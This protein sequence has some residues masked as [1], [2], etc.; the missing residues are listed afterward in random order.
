MTKSD[1]TPLAVL[2]ALLAVVL[3]SC[4][5]A[6]S[7]WRVFGNT[8]DEPEHLAAGIELL[9]QGK[10]TYDI[11]HPP[12]ARVLLA[13]G[14]W[15]S[16]AHSENTPPPNGEP[17]GQKILY[18]EGHYD[19]YLSLARA[20]T[21]PFLA[22]L[23]VVTFLWARSVTTP[24]VSL[25]AALLLTTTPAVIG[26]GALATIDI[27][28]ASTTLFA[29]WF[30]RRWLA[31]G[32]LLDA[33]ALGL[34]SGLALGTKLS[35]LPFAGVGGPLLWLLA[36]WERRRRGLPPVASPSRWALGG[37]LIVLLIGVVLTEAYGGRFIYLTNAQHKFSQAL[38]YLF[39]FHGFLHDVA[40]QVFSWVKVPEAVKWFLGGIEAVSVHNQNGHLSYL[41]GESRAQGWYYFYL[42]ALAV[43]T[44][45]PFLVLGILGLVRLAW[46]G[47][48]SSDARIL[49]PP[50][51]F[52]AL[53]LFVSLFSHINIGVRH[54]LVLYPLLAI[55]AATLLASL[56]DRLRGL[57]SERLRLVLGGVLVTLTLWPAVVVVREWPDYLAYFNLLAPDP[58]QVLVDS[59]L[60][61]GQDLQRLSRRLHILKV[62]S[63][64]LAYDGSA[65]LDREGLP[66]YR[67]LG[68]DERA[69]GW[70]A[71]TALARV[72]APERFQWLNAYP[73]VEQVGKT[74]DL[75]YVPLNKPAAPAQ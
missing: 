17:E 45:L 70:I 38:W 28:A 56:W 54:V 51:L 64:S 13:L 11:Q 5:L 22:L 4:G 27:A 12:I 46:C 25:G 23:V 42:V 20:G 58:E 29:L 66:P 19:L 2:I 63:I 39:G 10:Y 41:L 68:P 57:S 21:L 53:L 44:P 6:A 69:T 40:Y 59:D 14:P 72:H 55:G 50:A 9:D 18:S 60:D 73:R 65:L 35:A 26:H 75:Y 52:A 3:L 47:L 67:L 8:W 1:P 24:W 37:L 16:G 31:S 49:T 33:L 7:T 34:A 62:P 43:K 48:R 71:V 15:L 61:W 30:A 74:I 36:W 32:K